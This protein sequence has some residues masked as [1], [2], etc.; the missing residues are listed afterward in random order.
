L[1]LIAQPWRHPVSGVYYIRRFVPRALRPIIGRVEIRRSLGTTDFRQAKALFADAYAATERLINEA[2]V[3]GGVSRQTIDALPGNTLGKAPSSA[4]ALDS[5]PK[6]AIPG[7]EPSSLPKL[8]Q[9]LDRHIES[10]VL[11]NRPEHVRANHESQLRKVVDRFIELIGDLAINRITSSHVQT[12]AVEL[13]MV[14]VIR[15]RKTKSADIAQLK[16]LAKP[17]TPTLSSATVR[18]TV[19][20]LSSLMSFAVESGHISSNPVT[21]SRVLRKL[22]AA[23]PKR[24]LDDDKGYN[25]EELV[26]L[27][28][29]SDF[30]S[31]RHATGRPGNAVFWLP[32]LAAYTGARREEIAQLYVSDVH[33]HKSGQWLIRIID[34]RPDKSVKTHS[35]RRDIPIHDDLLALG[36]LELVHGQEQ[37]TK[38]FAQLD[39]VSGRYSGIVAKHWRLLTQRCGVYRLGRHPLHA[40]RHSFKTLARAHGIPRDVS[41]WITGHAI[42]G[43]GDGYGINP[44]ART[45][46]EMKKIPSIAKAAGLITSPIPAPKKRP[47]ESPGF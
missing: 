5:P 44:I 1:A 41:D 16:K 18:L 39:K 26:K 25:W 14:P 21:A 31:Q 43:A 12:F 27:F 22:D 8:S 4:Y 23:K 47:E 33:Q 32:L 30:Q 42:G 28:S 13:A 36:F 45:A 6:A 9:V 19:A 7:Q 20:R 17:D 3:H 40:F 46:E 24:H 34:D 2:R 37:D 15:G 29:H 11:I 38:V 35:S 10:M